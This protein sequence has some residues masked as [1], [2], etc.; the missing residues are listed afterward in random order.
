MNIKTGLV[1]NNIHENIFQNN[2]IS[3][4]NLSLFEISL[5]YIGFT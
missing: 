2:G 3:L 5:I 4:T 1:S